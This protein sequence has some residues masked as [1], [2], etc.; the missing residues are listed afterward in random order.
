MGCG[1]DETTEE[2]TQPPPAVCEPKNVSMAPSVATCHVLHVTCHMSRVMCQNPLGTCDCSD[3]QLWYGPDCTSAF[4][5]LE[6]GNDLLQVQCSTVQ[7]STVQHSTVQ[8]PAAAG[9]G[10]G[11][12]RDGV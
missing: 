6:P 10:G 4:Y 3:N 12:V 7:Y 11:R 8:P 9:A 2:P 1:L 5:C